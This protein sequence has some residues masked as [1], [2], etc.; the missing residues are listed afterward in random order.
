MKTTILSWRK[1]VLLLLV[2]VIVACTALKDQKQATIQTVRSA[3]D[4]PISFAV[5]GTGEPTIVF[6]HCWTCDHQFWKHQIAYFSKKYKVVGLDLAGHGLSGS[7]RSDYTMAAFGQDVAAVVNQVGGH[8]VVLVGHSMGGPVAI[9]AAKILG[10]KVVAIVGVDTFYTPFELPK[11]EVKI[12]GF[13]KPFKKDFVGTSQQMVQSMFTPNVDPELKASIV[14][15]FPGA[16]PEI[17]ISAMYEL[18]RWNAQNAPACLESYSD[19]LWNINAAPTGNETALHKNVTLIPGVGHF[20]P[21]VKPEEFNA[22]LSKIIR[23]Y[24]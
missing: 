4:S 9:E 3:D 11:S 23:A 14:K 8:R 12:E 22:A 13:L 1:F 21:Q 20:I 7:M 18:I 5:Q 16:K 10:D 15:Q 6:V 19:K 2:S 24:Q 17:G